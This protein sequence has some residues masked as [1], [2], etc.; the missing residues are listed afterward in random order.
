MIPPLQR[1]FDLVGADVEAWY[2]EMPKYNRLIKRMPDVITLANKK[3]RVL[4]DEHF[5]SDRCAA[6]EE[7]HP[8][9]AVSRRNTCLD[10]ISFVL[11]RSALHSSVCPVSG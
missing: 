8:A 4:L 1:I 9:K 11:I 10:F 3:K 2:N 6:C 7:Q 5:S